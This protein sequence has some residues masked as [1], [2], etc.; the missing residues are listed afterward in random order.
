MA[1]MYLDRQRDVHVVR[2]R[3]DHRRRGRDGRLA[4]RPAGGAVQARRQRRT[5]AACRSSAACTRH[6]ARVARSGRRSST[7]CC[8]TRW[9]RSSRRRPCSSLLAVPALRLHTAT[10][11]SR[12]C[13]ATCRS[14]KTYDRIQAAFPGGPIA[15][16]RRVQGARRHARRRSTAGDR[17]RCASARV[18][19]RAQC[20]TRSR[21]VDQPRPDGRR[22]DRSR[23]PATA[24][25]PRPNRALRDAARR[26]HPG[27]ARQGAR[28]RRPT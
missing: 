24:P 26:A 5:R 28:R 1:G 27:D 13:R 4:D 14:M 3:H 19:T 9:S 16:G 12:A 10:R 11:A 7:A 22:R 25:T 8:A 18:A 23:S 20:A 6:G 2:D 21:V 15:G 17:A